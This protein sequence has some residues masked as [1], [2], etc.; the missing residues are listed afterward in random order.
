MTLG[1]YS[2]NITERIPIETVINV[3]VKSSLFTQK[4]KS[5]LRRGL[6]KNVIDIVD[7]KNPCS[8]TSVNDFS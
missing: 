8:F 6:A 2:S 7:L 3:R 5:R 1:V 4:H